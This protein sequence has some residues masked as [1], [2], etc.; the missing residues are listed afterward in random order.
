MV[1]GMSLIAI[2][3]VLMFTRPASIG[4]FAWLALTTG[5]TG[6]GMGAAMPA[7]NNATLSFAT[8]NIAAITGMRGMFRSMGSIIAV[9]VMTAVVTRS[10]HPGIALGWGFVALAVPTIAV[11]PLILTLRDHRGSW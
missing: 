11:I 6:I 7:A 4:A 10:A 5:L 3:S 2:G 1:I 9:S 8:D